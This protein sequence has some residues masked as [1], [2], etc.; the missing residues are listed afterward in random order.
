MERLCLP[1][2][3]GGFNLLHYETHLISLRATYVLRLCDARHPHWKRMLR[4][5][6]NDA[7]GGWIRDEFLFSQRSQMGSS[8]VDVAERPWSRTGLRF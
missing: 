8:R 7:T 4:A 3:Q 5:A 2:A 6:I 1:W